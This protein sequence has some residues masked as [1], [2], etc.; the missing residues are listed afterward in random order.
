MRRLLTRF[1]IYAVLTAA[2]AV[3]LFPIYAVVIMALSRAPGFSVVIAPDWDALTLDHFRKFVSTHDAEG[4]WLFGRQLVNSLVVAGST[5]VLG[6]GLATSCAYAL[7][8]FR[9]PG[10]R[11]ALGSL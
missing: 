2:A 1:A 10:H 5:T 7:S 6:I 8:R 3:A 9:F 11:A 4:R